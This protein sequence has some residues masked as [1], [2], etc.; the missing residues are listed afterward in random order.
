[1]TDEAP[2]RARKRPRQRRSRELVDVLLEATARVLATGRSLDEATTNEIAA[3]AGVS[4]GSLYQYFPNK[5]ALAAA[6]IEQRAARSLEEVGGA[7][8]ALAGR[9]FGE[10]LAAGVRSLVAM[11]R[12]ERA[13]YVAMFALV[14]EVGQHELVRTLAAQGREM[15]RQL[16]EAHRDELRPD[17]DLELAAFVV[18]HALEALVHAAV[19]EAPALLD[20]R[21]EQ[22]LVR[23][24]LGYLR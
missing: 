17:V 13:L 8:G 6:L 23:L 16:F 12:R 9:P 3:I 2:N 1:M 18:G 14:R 22:E 7:I 20:E 11:H 19:E 10:R 24:L 15:L 21:L 4:I 5:Q